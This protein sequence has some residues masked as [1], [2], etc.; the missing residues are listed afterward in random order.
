MLFCAAGLA[1]VTRAVDPAAPL[2]VCFCDDDI[3][4]SVSPS[5]L[6]W[7]F[8]G[9]AT[10]A[11]PVDPTR[12]WLGYWSTLHFAREPQLRF[13]SFSALGTLPSD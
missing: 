9:V 3:A 12:M 5:S 7:V 6:R 4:P 1:V 13:C 10:V 2:M 8:L 11:A